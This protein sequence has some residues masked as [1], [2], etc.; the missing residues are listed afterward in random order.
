MLCNKRSYCSE[1]PAHYSQRAAPVPCNQRRS[2]HGSKDSEQPKI[3]KIFE[4]ARL[5]KFHIFWYRR[6]IFKGTW[7]CKVF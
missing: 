3:N 4:K 1:K 7:I 2:L 5:N 6:K